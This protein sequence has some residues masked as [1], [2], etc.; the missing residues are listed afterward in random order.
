MLIELKR[1][2]KLY[3]GSLRNHCYKGLSTEICSAGHFG[4][5]ASERVLDGQY[6]QSD[7]A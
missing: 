2:N 6:Q 1:Q 4:F 5:A 7:F 3:K